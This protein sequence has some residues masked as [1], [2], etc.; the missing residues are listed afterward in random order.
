MKSKNKSIGIKLQK[1]HKQNLL[2]TVATAAQHWQVLM[3]QM[4]ARDI[5][6]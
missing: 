3:E 1:A 5:G 2:H 4:E 6:K